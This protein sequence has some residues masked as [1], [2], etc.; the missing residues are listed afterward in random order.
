[1]VQALSPFDL[2]IGG[3]ESKSRCKVIYTPISSRLP[4]V[5]NPYLP[6]RNKGMTTSCCP[7]RAYIPR[8]R[9]GKGSADLDA[10]MFRAGGLIGIVPEQQ[11]AQI[12]VAKQSIVIIVRDG[13]KEV[14]VVVVANSRGHGWVWCNFWG[15][16]S[17]CSICHLNTTHWRS[18]QQ[19]FVS[20]VIVVVL[21]PSF[22]LA[23]TPLVD[24]C[25][26]FPLC[27][28]ADLLLPSLLRSLGALP[29]ASFLLQIPLLCLA[30]PSVQ[31]VLPL[32]EQHTILVVHVSIVGA[33]PVQL[34]KCEP[35]LHQRIQEGTAGVGEA[36]RDGA[37]HARIASASPS[38]GVLALFPRPWRRAGFFWLGGQEVS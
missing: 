9:K 14:V 22:T 24:I 15:D 34:R 18:A 31:L 26:L 8:R 3:K 4:I 5:A 20:E 29:L 1:M 30:D 36:D 11:L 19:C 37:V 38:H 27:L 2:G 12:R 23:A 10:L 32:E 25:F 17:T 35:S 21:C 28:P 33:G 7:P 13:E 6:R 16:G